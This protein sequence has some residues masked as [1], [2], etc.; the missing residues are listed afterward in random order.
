VNGSAEAPGATGGS[1]SSLGGGGG[2]RSFPSV[3]LVYDEPQG[4]SFDDSLNIIV[5]S[6]VPL[7][8][9]ERVSIIVD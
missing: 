6:C 4:P 1:S 8:I 5:L 3:F 2:G 9:Y 7:I